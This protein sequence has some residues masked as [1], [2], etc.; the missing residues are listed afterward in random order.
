M[1]THQFARKPSSWDQYILGL[2][3]STGRVSDEDSLCCQSCGTWVETTLA[4]FSRYTG[5]PLC[6]GCA[7]AEGTVEYPWILPALPKSEDPLHEQTPLH[8]TL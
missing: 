4:S 5:E 8:V 6:P 3:T 1:S 2:K 7:Q